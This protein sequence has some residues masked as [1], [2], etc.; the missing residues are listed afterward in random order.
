MLA[1][2]WS[3][4]TGSEFYFIFFLRQVCAIRGPSS[5]E[6]WEAGTAFNSLIK[7]PPDLGFETSGGQVARWAA[8]EGARWLFDCKGAK[9]RQLWALCE[10]GPVFI[11]QGLF[12]DSSLKDHFGTFTRHPG[13]ALGSNHK[14]RHPNSSFSLRGQSFSPA[15]WVSVEKVLML[16]KS[17]PQDGPGRGMILSVGKRERKSLINHRAF[18]KRLFTGPR[19]WHCGSKGPPKTQTRGLES[20]ERTRAWEAS[21]LTQALWEQAGLYGSSVWHVG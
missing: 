21:G 11:L 17:T 5:V 3:G 4:E 13:I 1:G 7:N 12:Q 10:W 18:A 6:E 19:A 16:W 20:D 8:A 14:I 9:P 15:T 2:Q